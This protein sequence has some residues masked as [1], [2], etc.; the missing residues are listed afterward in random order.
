MTPD[1]KVIDVHTPKIPSRKPYAKPATSITLN[2]SEELFLMEWMRNGGDHV[3]ALRNAGYSES[4]TDHRQAY[5]ILKKIDD[6]CEIGDVFRLAGYGPTAW[7][8]RILSLAYSDNLKARSVAI[9]LWGLAAQY[10]SPQQQAAGASINVQVLQANGAD[11]RNAGLVQVTVDAR[12]PLPASHDIG[13]TR[14]TDAS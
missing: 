3:K 10:F 1:S 4:N 5:Q 8:E 2:Q 14:D 12:K 11:P 6:A 13:P 9:R 7:V